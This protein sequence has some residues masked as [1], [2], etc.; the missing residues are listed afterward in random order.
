[1][2]V[3]SAA[4]RAAFTPAST[5][6]NS[7][8]GPPRSRALARTSAKSV[9][10]AARR[11]PAARAARSGPP[12]EAP[13]A[14]RLDVALDAR[15]PGRRQR[16]DLGERQEP[17]EAPLAF[18]RGRPDRRLRARGFWGLRPWWLRPWWLRPRGGPRAARAPAGA[19][20]GARAPAGAAPAG[21]VRAH[22][23]A[24]GRRAGAR[25]A[26]AARAAPRARPARPPAGPPPP[27]RRREGLRL[28]V[29]QAVEHAAVVRPQQHDAAL[30]RRVLHKYF[31]AQLEAV[32]PALADR[33]DVTYTIREQRFHGF[34]VA[35]RRFP[36]V[37]H[38]FDLQDPGASQR[39]A[40]GGGG[41]GR[42]GAGAAAFLRIV[43]QELDEDLFFRGTA[44][45][46]RRVDPA[47][48]DADACLVA[49]A[50][51]AGLAL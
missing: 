17:A 46:R 19:G 16:G 28:D 12:G 9:A 35:R 48:V 5:S 43:R 25:G 10:S 40:G 14:H 6:L 42:S 47:L 3:W 21:A 18:G 49:R 13:L 41:R 15:R 20:K 8:D 34:R 39:V 33:A 11:S 24:R 22:R 37:R 23:A 44:G 29:A 38:G 2:A 32:D 4:S 26:R 36:D 45:A 1:M 50:A 7:R 31:R 51:R 30:H 27:L